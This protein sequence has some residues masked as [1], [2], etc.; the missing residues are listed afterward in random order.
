[1]YTSYTPEIFKL[2]DPDGYIKYLDEHGYVVIDD[3]IEDSVRAQLVE[4][5]WEC[6]MECSPNF[7]RNDKSTWNIKNSPMM[8][9]K[10]MAVFSGLP[11]C[12][13]AWATRLHPNI[14][15]VF[16]HIHGTDKLCTSFDGFSVFFTKDQHPPK[17]LHTDQHPSNTE[18]CIQGAYNFLPVTESSAGFIVVPG[19]HKETRD[20]KKSGDWVPVDDDTRAVK[21]LVPHN[22]LVLWN[23]KTVHAN[24]GMTSKE[25][26]LDRL[27]C[28]ITYL[29]KK[30]RSK[31][32][33][34]RKILAYIESNGT[35][36]W[37]NR[38][39]LKKYPWGF[40]PNYESRNFTKLKTNVEVPVEHIRVF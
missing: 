25:V 38:C 5:F 24:T 18:Y 35:S 29:P 4:K 39:E 28:Y 27:T 15:R 19:S 26:R 10:G 30:Y 13:F 22:T 14:K 23:S 20:T 34:E 1:M 3:I 40:G 9:A 36:H 31:Q 6:W 12:D 37:A 8:F 2:D 32:V 33:L 16:S 7:D 11:H 17:W 21:L